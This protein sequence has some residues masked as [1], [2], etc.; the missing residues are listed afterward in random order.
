[1]ATTDLIIR[2]EVADM[3]VETELMG[4]FFDEK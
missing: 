4:K 3:L 1:M 2:L